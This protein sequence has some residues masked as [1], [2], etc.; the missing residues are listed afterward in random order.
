MK[1]II[2]II[3]V[4]SYLFVGNVSAQNTEEKVFL[5]KQRIESEISKGYIYIQTVEVF[6]QRIKDDQ[7]KL[8]SLL[9]RVVVLE[10]QLSKKENKTIK[11]KH[12]L[13][14]VTYIKYQIYLEITPLEEKEIPA[15][16]E[17]KLPYVP[18]VPQIQESSIKMFDI[19]PDEFTS[20]I[21]KK[22][23]SALENFLKNTYRQQSPNSSPSITLQNHISLFE[24]IEDSTSQIDRNTQRENDL[25]YIQKII[26][27]YYKKHG[28]YPNLEH[29]RSISSTLPKD[30]LWGYRVDKC[31]YGYLY[32]TWGNGTH[33]RL[34]ACMEWADGKAISLSDGG[35]DNF[36][37]ELGNDVS[38]A[39]IDTRFI[40]N[41]DIFYISLITSSD[42]WSI[43]TL[44]TWANIPVYYGTFTP[45][46][47]TLLRSI[48]TAQYEKANPW[49]D[50]NQ[51]TYDV[52]NIIASALDNYYLSGD[53]LE[54]IDHQE[55]HEGKDMFIAWEL[56]ALNNFKV[57]PIDYKKLWLWNNFPKDTLGTDFLLAYANTWWGHYQI[58][59]FLQ[60]R[61]WNAT[62][63][64]TTIRGTYAPKNAILTEGKDYEKISENEIQLT[65]KNSLHLFKRGE[66]IHDTLRIEW[67][68]YDT[69]T[70]RMDANI[71][72]LPQI[73]FDQPAGLIR[74]PKS[75]KPYIDGEIVEIR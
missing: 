48:A 42:T 8:N 22:S 15:L 65:D 17:E 47:E 45:D 32:N 9:N 28:T 30:V 34:S 29:M 75:G 2:S 31:R 68:E 60:A 21:N 4:C 19:S 7:R 20:D 27:K 44:S 61:E 58:V 12:I 10:E 38:K 43:H 25:E 59:W 18:A 39:E 3:L 67:I 26:E 64:K 23:A 16:K 36:R 1:Y 56:V 66:N 72:S 49:R 37:Y 73:I 11:E 40:N 70:L 13:M 62:Y 41:G 57:G 14:I 54:V 46:R 52:M 51:I 69:G 55:I 53:I 5:L 71:Q 6:V 33:Y 35:I 24:T 50:K 63:Q 74:N